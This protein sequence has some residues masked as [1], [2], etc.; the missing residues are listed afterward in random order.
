LY[1]EALIREYH[2]AFV[3]AGGRARFELLHGV[4]GDG[5]LLRLYPDRWRPI[6]DEFLASL[7]RRSP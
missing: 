4:P 3:A 2:E 6:A 5:H 7:N 1:D